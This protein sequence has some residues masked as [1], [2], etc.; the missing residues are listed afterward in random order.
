GKRRRRAEALARCRLQPAAHLQHRRASL[1][2]ARF[3][4]SAPRRAGSGGRPD[5]LAGA[6]DQRG[7]GDEERPGRDRRTRRA[8]GRRRDHRDRQF[9]DRPV[10]SRPAA[11]GAA[12]SHQAGRQ[13]HS[14]CR[15]L[16]HGAHRRRRAHSPD[17]RP[18]LRSGGREGRAARAA[19]RA[20]RGRL[21]QRPGP[22]LR[23]ADERGRLPRLDR[24]PAEKAPDRL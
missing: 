15:H 11:R 23:P 5:L 9:R 8:S 2:P 19:R 7:D 4:R 20:P 10:Q 13:P 22:C 6:R 18:G 16:R 1:Q 12:R 24:R 3:L 21:R 17:Q 14:R